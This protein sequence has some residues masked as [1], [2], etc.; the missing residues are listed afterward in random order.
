MGM[1]KVEQKG[2]FTHEIL[3]LKSNCLGNNVFSFRL[4]RYEKMQQVVTGRHQTPV[5]F[6]TSIYELD[7]VRQTNSLEQT[8]KGNIMK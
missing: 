2:I 1:E 8:R 3:K 4:L 6:P 5:Q 7:Y